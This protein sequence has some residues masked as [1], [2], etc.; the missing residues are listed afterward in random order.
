LRPFKKG[1]ANALTRRSYYFVHLT[2]ELHQSAI[3]ID[4]DVIQPAGGPPEALQIVCSIWAPHSS[5]SFCPRS[6]AIDSS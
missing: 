3:A 6:A 2:V 4:F 1:T 5:E